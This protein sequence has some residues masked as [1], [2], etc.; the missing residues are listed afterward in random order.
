MK[1][2]EIVVAGLM[3]AL[4]FF[5]QRLINRMDEGLEIITTL[6][7]RVQHLEEHKEECKVFQKEHTEKLHQME[8]F[9]AKTRK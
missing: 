1:Y 6:V 9:I 7:A 4:I 3:G 8:K 2:A 5:I